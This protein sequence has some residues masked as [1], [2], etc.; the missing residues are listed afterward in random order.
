MTDPVAVFKARKELDWVQKDNRAT[1]GLKLWYK[2]ILI[3]EW[4]LRDSKFFVKL[5]EVRLSDRGVDFQH[6]TL[7]AI[8]RTQEELRRWCITEEIGFVHTRGKR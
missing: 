1:T 4:G 8:N 3:A 7:G 2:S 5:P 6:Q